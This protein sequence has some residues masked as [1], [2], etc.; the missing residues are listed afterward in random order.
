M[1]SLQRTYGRPVSMRRMKPG[2]RARASSSNSPE[3]VTIPAAF[4][5]A[6]PSPR[7][8]GFGS[9]IAETTS[10]TPAAINASVHGGVRPWWQHGSRVT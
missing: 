2:F 10:A 7:T 1:A 3:R 4:S 5:V 8:F 9:C 6:C